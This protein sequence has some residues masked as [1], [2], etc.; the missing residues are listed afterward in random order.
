MNPALSQQGP[1]V[2]HWSAGVSRYDFG[3]T[4][5]A[6]SQKVQILGKVPLFE[7][8]AEEDLAAI[9]SVAFSRSI[10]AREELFHQGDEGTHVY[11]VASGQLKVVT[12]SS[13]GDD[14]IFCL[15]DPGEVIGELGLLANRPRTA[16]ITAI[17]DSELIVIDRRDFRAL[18]RTRPDVAF[19]LLTVL[20]C[21]LARVSE[22]VEDTQF[23][24]LPARLAKKLINFA[25][26]HGKSGS[27]SSGHALV[28]DVK[29]SQEEWGDL[30]GTTRES[31]NK[32]FRAWSSEGLISLEAGKVVI[33]KLDEIE[34]MA[35]CVVI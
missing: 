20:A 25:N 22:F 35:A 12:T 7:S 23:L 32:Q 9:A 17:K 29:L 5:L 27:G 10:K 14:L 31:V 15:L 4:S 18:L 1:F 30:V 2:G 8:L 21:R 13:D 26:L 34:K 11:V 3:M 28:I 33:H 19:E 6:L 16:T 24:N